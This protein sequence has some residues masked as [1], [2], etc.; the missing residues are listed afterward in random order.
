MPPAEV[1][2]YRGQGWKTQAEM[3]EL[4]AKW[5]AKHP[6]PCAMCQGNGWMYEWCCEGGDC[7]CGGARVQEPCCICG[8][9]GTRP[10]KQLWL[11]AELTAQ[12]EKQ[13]EATVGTERKR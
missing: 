7:L 1:P 4:Q 10:V 3:D 2:A 12:I 13:Y 9:T 11:T 6:E 5:R 8:G